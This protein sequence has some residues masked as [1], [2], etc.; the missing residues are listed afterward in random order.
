VTAIP[1]AVKDVYAGLP[2][3]LGQGAVMICLFAMLGI[4]FYLL[5]VP[6]GGCR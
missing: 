1:Q 4:G 2:T 6:G 3:A 5:F